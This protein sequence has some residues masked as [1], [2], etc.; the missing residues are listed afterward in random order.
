MVGEALGASGALQTVAA[1]AALRHGQVAGIHRLQEPD[2]E[3]E[4][5]DLDTRVRPP[6]GEAALIT[7]Q[8]LDGAAAALLVAA[9]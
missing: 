2:P 8:G 9:S 3:L 6:T 7:A 4:T 1:L 5:L